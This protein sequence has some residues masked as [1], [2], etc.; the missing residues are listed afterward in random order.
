MNNFLTESLSIITNTIYSTSPALESSR[1]IDEIKMSSGYVVYTDT[2]GYI[3][4]VIIRSVG[5]SRFLLPP[6]NIVI[7]PSLTSY[8]TDLTLASFIRESA[9]LDRNCSIYV[10]GSDATYTFKTGYIA[11]SKDGIL[12]M[13]SCKV[14]KAL[15]KSGRLIFEGAK[16]ELSPVL[17]AS[18]DTNVT[19]LR[20]KIIK[21]LNESMFYGS[22][23]KGYFID[24]VPYEVKKLIG[25]TVNV[26]SCPKTDSKS[27]IIITINNI[28]SPFKYLRVK[29][30]SIVNCA[31]FTNTVYKKIEHG[32]WF[33]K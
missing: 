17:F 33:S 24:D 28:E 27:G 6:V 9:D 32:N 26:E 4:T 5:K 20:K 2:S 8:K 18:K 1:C 7:N 21:Y 19:Y 31:D 29:E 3:P 10:T 12:F 25:G 16:I 14:N 11:S 15:S 23:E 13:S 30:S 22:T